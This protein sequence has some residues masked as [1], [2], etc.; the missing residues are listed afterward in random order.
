MKCKPE[1]CLEKYG[2]CYRNLL[3]RSRTFGLM[4]RAFRDCIRRPTSDDEE[5]FQADL[6]RKDTSPALSCNVSNTP[7]R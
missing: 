5:T 6:A 2:E 7:I 1:L 3:K 4:K